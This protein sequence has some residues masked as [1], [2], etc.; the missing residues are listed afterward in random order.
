MH[1]HIHYVIS[2]PQQPC[3]IRI[4]LLLQMR[5]LRPSDLPKDTCLYKMQP[6]IQFKFSNPQ[7]NALAFTVPL[8]LPK[9]NYS[10]I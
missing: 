4:I 5:K 2:F 9:L 8:S 3:G 7:I 10:K 1:F 6:E